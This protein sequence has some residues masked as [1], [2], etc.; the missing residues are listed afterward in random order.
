MKVWFAPL[1]GATDAIFRRVHHACFT[2]VEKYYI[3]FVSPTQNLLFTS[4]ELRA[5][6]PEE[7]EGVPAVPQLLGKDPD[8]LLWAIGELK[9]MGYG[10]VNLNLGCPS[11]TVTAKGKGSGLLREKDSLR[12][13][14]DG[15]YEKTLL[16]LSV[17]TRIGFADPEEWPALLE[18]LRQYPMAELIIHPRTRKDFYK[19]PLHP[20]TFALAAEQVSCPLVYNGDLFTAQDCRD[21]AAQYPQ[22]RAVMIG[23]GLMANPAMAQTLC[24]GEALTADALRRFHDML[25]E[26]YGRL[27]PANQVHS[28]VR[29]VMK[30]AACCFED[31]ARPRKAIRKAKDLAEHHQAVDWLLR[32][33]RLRENPGYEPDSWIV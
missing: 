4:R 6:A 5:I 31:A 7:N 28:R 27:Y 25:C 8:Q 20:Q 10:E 11:G 23:R 24:G 21:I 13:V 9:N 19:G 2:G 26:A 14:L 18:I 22:L 3:P 15:V 29:E 32:D 30:Y 16:P 33:F 1:E 17:K 12:R